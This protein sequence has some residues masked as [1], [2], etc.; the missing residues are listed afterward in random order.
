MDIFEEELLK[1]GQSP[2]FLFDPNDAIQG[3]GFIDRKYFQFCMNQVQVDGLWMECGVYSGASLREIREFAPKTIK[4]VYG[5]D[6][7]EGLPEAWVKS[8]NETLP[9]SFFYMSGQ[10]PNYLKTKG[11]E[12]VVGY[13]EDTIDKFLEEH[14]EPIAFLHLDADLYSS[15]KTILDALISKNRLVKGSIIC[16]DELFGYENYQEGELKAILESG[17]NYEYLAHTNC[18]ACIRIL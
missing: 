13:F 3:S 8:Q 15:T 17:L 11:I 9:K 14:E 4:T 6:S 2:Y 5:A 18:Q 12:L 16:L 10:P 1:I 7:F